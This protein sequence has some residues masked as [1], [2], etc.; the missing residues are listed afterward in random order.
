MACA[1]GR[2]GSWVSVLLYLFSSFTSS[3]FKI[4][5]KK[6]FID[7]ALLLSSF[8]SE[9]DNHVAERLLQNLAPVRFLNRSAEAFKPGFCKWLRI[10]GFDTHNF[11]SCTTQEGTVRRLQFV[12]GDYSFRYGNIKLAANVHHCLACD[13]G[14]D[15]TQR[16][17]DKFA[18]LFHEEVCP[19]RLCYVAMHVEHKR[20]VIAANFCFT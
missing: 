17:R 15:M 13:S 3:F 4:Q 11:C 18:V 12:G 14:K 16:R 2:V 8:C 10:D 20:F 5:L 19:G 1:A 6:L 7:S 9:S